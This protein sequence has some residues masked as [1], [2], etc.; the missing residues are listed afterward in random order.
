[1]KTEIE[2]EQNSA[3]DSTSGAQ[4]LRTDIKSQDIIDHF[5]REIKSATC[6]SECLQMSPNPANFQKLT[7]RLE[8]RRMTAARRMA[9]LLQTSG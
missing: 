7:V 8:I 6:S 3:V 4:N 2:L 9:E 5:A 1:M